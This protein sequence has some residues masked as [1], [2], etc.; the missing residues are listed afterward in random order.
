MSQ[1]FEGPPRLLPKHRPKNGQYQPQFFSV[2]DEQATDKIPRVARLKSQAARSIAAETTIELPQAEALNSQRPTSA[3][4]MVKVPQTDGLKSQR[5]RSISAEV[6]LKIPRPVDL[7][8]PW[9]RPLSSL[10]SVE[11]KER[12]RPINSPHSGQG[13]GPGTL[14]SPGGFDTGNDDLDFDK[15]STIPIQVVRGIAKQQGSAQ[16]AM[17]AEI[18]EAAGS[19]AYVSIGNV[20]GTVLR[21]GG[22]LVIQRGFGAGP[23]GIYTLGMSIVTLATAIFNLGLDDAMVRYVSI[24]RAKRQTNLLRGLAIFCSAVVGAS[25]MLGALLLFNMAPFLATL[26][27]SPE[28]LPILQLMAPIVPLMCL[29]TIWISGLQGFKDFK[30]RVLIQRILIP[31]LL[32]V[33]LLGALFLFHDLNAIVIATLVNALIGTVLALIFFFRKVVSIVKPEP[34]AYELGNWFGFAIP[35]FLTSIVDTLLESIDTLLLAYFA[36]SSVALGQY[37]AAIKI[38]AFITT[39]QASFNAM[40]APTIAELHSQG[41]HEKLAALFKI[42]TKWAI[43]F[44][45]PIFAIA[46]LFS[47]SLLGIGGDSF[48][49]AW[50]LVIAFS[51]GTLINVSTGSV[52]YMLLMTGHQRLSFLNSLTAVIVNIVVGIIL[53]PRYGAMG[54]AI[55]T[56]LAVGVVNLMRLLQVGLLVKMQPYSWTVLKP[57]GATL[58]ASAATGALLYLLSLAHLSVQIYRLHLSFELALVPVF[59]AIYFGL[60]YLFKVSPEDKIVLDM[61]RRKFRRGKK[62]KKR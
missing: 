24:Y 57:I 36:I 25:G 47:R 49:S 9:K 27:H 39:P 28:V 55:A 44:S 11:Q 40:F 21:Y 31:M 19:A 38:S 22:N 4:A 53:A 10:K 33:L 14:D 45:L 32:I 3:E 41:E 43:T 13:W 17:K 46:V 59:I 18:S 16:P 15:L 58:L 1:R 26:R 2:T 52:G 42:V 54:V 23:F 37:A 62:N 60:L 6:T 20:G 8:V 30:W 5:E 29:Q 51:V 7:Q 56:G 35:N 48:V 61:L 34:E 12:V 50:P